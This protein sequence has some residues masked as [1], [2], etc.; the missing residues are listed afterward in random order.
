[1]SPSGSLVG[2][3]KISLGQANA[4]AI[5]TDATR[6]VRAYEEAV[7]MPTRHSPSPRPVQKDQRTPAVT[8]LDL[9]NAGILETLGAEEGSPWILIAIGTFIMMMA[10]GR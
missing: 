10:A 9:E 2:G 6:Y 3:P 7:G 8:E 4:S 1:M 5:D